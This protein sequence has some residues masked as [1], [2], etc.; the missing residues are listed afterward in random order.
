MTDLTVQTSIP[1]STNVSLGVVQVG[2]NLTV[3]SNG[4]LSAPDPTP[5]YI[6]QP[7]TTSSLGGIIVGSGLAV[8]SSGTLSVD[9]DAGK[10]EMYSYLP[11]LPTA[12]NQ[13]QDIYLSANT[14]MHVIKAVYPVNFQWSGSV[15]NVHI[16][17]SMADGETLEFYVDVSP[18]PRPGYSPTQPIAFTVNVLATGSIPMISGYSGKVSSV[19]INP[20]AVFRWSDALGSL[21]T[22][23]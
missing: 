19:T 2:A 1:S 12:S 14:G 9:V 6:L 4:V 20:Y 16:P 15:I 7:A 10:V 22:L 13:T 18:V 17:G 11:T 23:V 21:V 3:D 5:E 8:D